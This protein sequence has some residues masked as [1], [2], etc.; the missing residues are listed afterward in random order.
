MT[1]MR[2]RDGYSSRVHIRIILE[3]SCAY[4]THRRPRRTVAN[5]TSPTDCDGLGIGDRGRERE[6]EGGVNNSVATCGLSEG[7]GE[8][9]KGSVSRAVGRADSSRLAPLSLGKESQLLHMWD[10]HDPLF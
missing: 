1:S 5:L 3:A 9:V 2:P 7:E 8:K 6:R 10:H 4:A